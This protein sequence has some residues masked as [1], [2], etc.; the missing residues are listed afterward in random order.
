MVSRLSDNYALPVL[1]RLP[2]QIAAIIV[3]SG[4]KYLVNRHA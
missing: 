4:N 2:E 1:P 3:M